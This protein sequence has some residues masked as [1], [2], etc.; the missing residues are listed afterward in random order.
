MT[1]KILCFQLETSV[2]H[3]GGIIS[4]LLGMPNKTSSLQLNCEISMKED[5]NL[6]LMNIF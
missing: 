3:L 2:E 5:I 6:L 4:L 1:I